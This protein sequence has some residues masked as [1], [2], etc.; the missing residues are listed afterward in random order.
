M[1]KLRGYPKIE[2]YITV[3]LVASKKVRCFAP[4]LGLG[5][6]LSTHA[7]A[8]HICTLI[9]RSGPVTKENVIKMQD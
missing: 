5:Y 9:A 1:N 6:F 3:P 2:L 8:T 4:S 7:E